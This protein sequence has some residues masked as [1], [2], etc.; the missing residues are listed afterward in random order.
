MKMKRNILL[1]RI[2]YWVGAIIDAFVGLAMISP[3]LF[4]IMEGFES[5][6][7]GFDYMFA[8]GMGA[9][10]MFGWT[11]LLLWADRKP[12]E[13]KD[14]LLITVFPV[15]VGI[16]INRVIA[17]SNQFV[18][19]QGSFVSLVIPVILVFLFLTSYLY[20]ARH[21]AEFDT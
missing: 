19:I 4:A 2:S 7:P 17:I 3:D 9:P 15:I 1:L 13:R 18:T 5:F 6:T 8:M 10:L 16:Y 20:S 11:L 14:I 12:M 21:S